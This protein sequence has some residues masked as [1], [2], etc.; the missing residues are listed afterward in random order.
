ME[1]NQ[2][3]TYEN[4]DH[5]GTREKLEDDMTDEFQGQVKRLFNQGK[6]ERLDSYLDRKQ[7]TKQREDSD[8]W[9]EEQLGG[10]Q[11]SERQIRQSMLPEI[12]RQDSFDPYNV[13]AASSRFD[14]KLK[15][16][17]DEQRARLK[18]I[19][20]NGYKNHLLDGKDP[21][22]ESY[23]RQRAEATS[24]VLDKMSTKQLEGYIRA[25]P[26]Y[27][28][29][30]DVNFKSNAVNQVKRQRMARSQEPN[31]DSRP[32]SA[33]DTNDQIVAS[34]QKKVIPLDQMVIGRELMGLNPYQ[35][36]DKVLQSQRVV[37]DTPIMAKQQKMIEY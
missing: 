4:R 2:L 17:K 7:K 13:K 30:I 8:R 21:Q 11:P 15:L 19:R 16:I 14:D 6:L 35:P 3:Q 34:H 25:K 12:K 23:F 10:T 28:G 27:P 9:I 33:T 26:A 20:L 31:L 5:Y 24:K 37:L 29:D 1:P 32:T 36:L 22:P 18:L